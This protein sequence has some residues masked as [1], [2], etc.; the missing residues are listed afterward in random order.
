M[1][2]IKGIKIG[3]YS[4]K[5]SSSGLVLSDSLDKKHLTICYNIK[6]NAI[7]FHVKSDDSG[8]YNPGYMIH[9]DMLIPKINEFSEILTELIDPIIK[10]ITSSIFK[11][12][13]KW[14]SERNY[15]INK[16]DADSMLNIISKRMPVKK[17]RYIIE[18]K[19]LNR[20]LKNWYYKKDQS[21][22]SLLKDSNNNLS[23]QIAIKQFTKDSRFRIIL[24]PGKNKYEWFGLRLSVIEKIFE[25]VKLPFSE[26]E[27]DNFME[28]IFKGFNIDGVVEELS[29]LLIE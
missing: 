20:N 13:P 9:M 29:T 17:Q 5:L 12:S 27:V 7:D 3:N 21:P 25:N 8:E 1:G 18:K 11:I 24:I 28:M 4:I 10:Q 22:Y 16:F 19:T 23:F 2:I 14:L 15:F 26:E 6:H